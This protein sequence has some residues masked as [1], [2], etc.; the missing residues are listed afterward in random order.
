V[1]RHPGP[2]II[3][4]LV[5]S[6]FASTGMLGVRYN[7]DQDYLMTPTNGDSKREK[8]IAE[9]YFSTNFSD[10]DAPRS[11]EFGLFGYVMVT[12]KDGR[13]SILQPQIWGEVRRLQDAIVAISVQQDGRNYTYADLC[14][15][16]AGR[17]YTNSLLSFADTFAV[18]SE[19]VFR[20]SVEDYYKEHSDK[21]EFEI[22]NNISQLSEATSKEIINGVEKIQLLTNSTREMIQ[23][24]LEVLSTAV[25]GL[26]ELTLDL[27]SQYRTHLAPSFSGTSLPGYLGG[28]TVQNKSIENFDMCQILNFM[29]GENRSL[30]AQGSDCSHPMEIYSAFSDIY[31][32]AESEVLSSK[33]IIEKV[34]KEIKTALKQLN[35]KESAEKFIGLLTNVSTSIEGFALKVQDLAVVP[36]DEIEITK[37]LEAEAVLIGGLIDSDTYPD[38][39][40]LWEDKFLE[41]IERLASNFTNIEIAPVV[42]NSL[43]YEMI[44]SVNKI[45]PILAANIVVV[46]V[47]CMIVC[48]TRDTVTSKPWVGLA[49]V[50]STL[51]G[52]A[53]GFGLCVYAGADFTSF[54]YGAIFILLG[55]GMDSTFMLLNAWHRTH[56]KAPVPERLAETMAEAGVSILITNTTNILSFLIAISAP[57]PYVKIFC[58]YTGISLLMVFIFHIT[59]FAGCLAVSGYTEAAGRSGLTLQQK[60]QEALTKYQECLCLRMGRYKISRSQAERQQ[61]ARERQDQLA[62]VLGRVV[63]SST[64]RISVLFLYLSYLAI[65]IY[66]ICNVV[67]FFDKTKLIT[68]DSTMKKFVDVEDRLFRDK[69]FSI[70]VIVKGDFNYTVPGTLD[71]IDELLDQLEES[72]YI[73]EHLTKSWLK[74][75]QTFTFLNSTDVTKQTE[76]EF[77]KSV[78]RFYQQQATTSP[79]RLDVAFSEDKTRIAASRFLIHGQNLRNTK[80][81]EHMLL[82]LRRICR[83]VSERGGMQV[84]VYNSYFPYTDQYL[85]IFDQSIQCILLT[86]VIVVAVSLL[87]LPDTISAVSAIFSIISTLVGCLG[88]MSIW[89]IVL[90]GITLINL[91]MCI[92]FSVDFSAHFCYHYIEHRHTPGLDQDQVVE[93]TVLCVYR[94]VLQGAVSTLLGVI[95]MLYAPSYSFIIFFKVM[96]I[97]ISLGVFHSLILVP[98]FFRFTLDLIALVKVWRRKVPQDTRPPDIVKVVIGDVVIH[99]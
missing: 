27:S 63:R 41:T 54:N 57:Y 3:L 93:R 77:V 58:L 35:L 5:F 6:F 64:V 37:M 10:F 17:C 14:T 83:E 31:Q 86:G 16:W 11:F 97:V 73:N 13:S 26:N 9:T 25:D 71:S 18:F 65:C 48:C 20:N 84:T 56:R 92:G 55:I 69:S 1:G 51:A 62:G 99:I 79:Y 72:V 85:T 44:A 68:Y 42:S 82:E 34:N 36:R 22:A 88:L 30:E 61:E 19:G 46:V 50:I 33:L 39:G 45:K 12:A 29:R 78:H 21:F 59:F 70:S 96:F 28:I 49:G 32:H 43:R 74:D 98:L 76:E 23:R 90:D 67:V 60:E 94:P 52:S 4:P 87:L 2:F 95:G 89:G 15:K 8:A 81:E 80:D 91:I 47:F 7:T 53:T 38:I 66:G 40:V 75:F 24:N